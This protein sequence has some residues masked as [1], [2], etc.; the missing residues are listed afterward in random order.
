[1]FQCIKHSFYRLNNTGSHGND[2]LCSEV[3]NVAFSNLN[4]YS[5]I[6]GWYWLCHGLAQ[7][8]W[9]FWQTKWHWDRFFSKFFGF[10][11]SVLFHWHSILLHHLGDQQQAQWWLQFRD[12]S[13]TPSTQTTTIRMILNGLVMWLE[14][15]PFIWEVLCSV[16][17]SESGYSDKSFSLFSSVSSDKC[18]GSILK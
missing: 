18:Q 11:L 6:Y 4:I 15:L 3:T 16:P 5:V 13:L 10:F 2:V 8:M 9:D 7:F 1:M 17:G 12:H 14:C